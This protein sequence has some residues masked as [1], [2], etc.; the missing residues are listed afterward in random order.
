MR[1]EWKLPLDCFRLPVPLVFGTG[2]NVGRR[3]RVDPGGSTQPLSN[4]YTQVESHA[5]AATMARTLNDV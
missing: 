3:V 5:S 4:S 2:G 1:E